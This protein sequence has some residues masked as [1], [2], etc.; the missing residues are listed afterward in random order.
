MEV[1]GSKPVPGMVLSLGKERAAIPNFQKLVFYGENVACPGSVVRSIMQPFR[2]TLIGK[3]QGKAATR[4][5]IPTGALTNGRDSLV[6][7]LG[8]VD[9]L[10]RVRFPVAALVHRRRGALNPILLAPY[11][12]LLTTFISHGMVGK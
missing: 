4:V 10:A 3:G 9:P 8:T 5:Q 11:V 6:V 7:E 1:A 12:N 2:V